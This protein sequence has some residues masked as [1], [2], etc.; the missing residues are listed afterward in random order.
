MP[1]IVLQIF[2][3]LLVLSCV[4]SAIA[5]GRDARMAVAMM[6]AAVLLTRGVTL[7]FQTRWP[8]MIVDTVLLG[9]FIWLSVKSR[10]Y[11]PVWV[12]GLHGVS[13]AAHIATQLGPPIPYPVYHGV[14]G[15]WSIPVLL[16]MT[17]GIMLDQRAGLRN[18]SGDSARRRAP[19]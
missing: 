19:D 17:L 7:T 11:W 16:A 9:G 2:F 13:V 1:T 18:G 6:V 3:A 5:G 8:L 10:R 4:Y 12:T 14:I 15:V